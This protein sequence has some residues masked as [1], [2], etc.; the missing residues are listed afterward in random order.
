MVAVGKISTDRQP[1]RFVRALLLALGRDAPEPRA[2]ELPGQ[3]RVVAI[4]QVGGLQHRY[5]RRAA[6]PEQ[7]GWVDVAFLERKYGFS[8]IYPSKHLLMQNRILSGHEIPALGWHE[9]RTEFSVNH[10]RKPVFTLADFH[11]PRCWTGR[12][13]SFQRRRSE[14]CEVLRRAVP[15]RILLIDLLKPSVR[16]RDQRGKIN[17]WRRIAWCHCCV[18]YVDAPAPKNLSW[19]PDFLLATGRAELCKL[20]KVTR[21]GRYHCYSQTACAHC[22]Q[23][24]VG[25]APLPD[26]LVIVL[27]G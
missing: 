16:I 9:V 15:R 24:I 14:P 18:N 20:P 22:N 8:L 5:Q 4:P 26:F 17:A 25:Q 7:A 27:G 12:T 11:V 3:G 6:Q 23:R 21:I 19:C 13:A 2:V 10:S 1:H